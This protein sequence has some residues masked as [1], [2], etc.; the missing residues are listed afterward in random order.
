MRLPPLPLS[1]LELELFP[2][3]RIL[4]L[5]LLSLRLFISTLFCLSA[6]PKLLGIG[7]TPSPALL[8][9]IKDRS[10]SWFELEVAAAVHVW[11]HEFKLPVILLPFFATAVLISV[12]A[13]NITPPP[14]SIGISAAI[15]QLVLMGGG[16]HVWVFVYQ[17]VRL[18]RLTLLTIIC[19]AILLRSS[20]SS[21]NMLAIAVICPIYLGFH[22]GSIL[23]VYCLN[24]GK[25][26]R[27]MPRKPKSSRLKFL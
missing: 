26:L 14:H 5:L 13:L 23:T 17:C 24:Y 2:A 16:I 21:L 1:F 4:D 12:L 10:A 15:F 7:K 22:A 11:D 20:F 27:K 8:K 9:K 6:I 18:C 3:Y 19:I 25:V